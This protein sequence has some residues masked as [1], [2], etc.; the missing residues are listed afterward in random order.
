MMA[1]VV[2][3]SDNGTDLSDELANSFCRM[4]ASVARH[5]AEVTFLS[6]HRED[7]GGLQLPTLV[8]QCTRDALAPVAVSDYLRTRW[9]EVEIAHL[10]ATGHCPHMSAPA[11]TVAVLREFLVRHPSALEASHAC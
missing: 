6:D 4:D 11:E 2:M 10:Q 3:G 5:F 8:M 7:L 1:P 9:P